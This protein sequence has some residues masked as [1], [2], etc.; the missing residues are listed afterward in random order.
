MLA[1]K[2]EEMKTTVEIEQQDYLNAV[3]PFRNGCSFRARFEADGRVLL[4]PGCYCLVNLLQGAD[5]WFL[6]RWRENG[7]K[8]FEI[9][10]TPE[11]QHEIL[12][13]PKCGWCDGT[14]MAN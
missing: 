3:K 10:L 2:G 5:R 8:P 4:E 14:L 7:E 13:I 11:T 1:S 9:H 6:D 12:K